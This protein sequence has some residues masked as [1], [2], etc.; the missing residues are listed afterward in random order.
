[1]VVMEW[2]GKNLKCQFKSNNFVILS[3]WLA[4]RWKDDTMNESLLFQQT[5]QTNKVFLYFFRFPKKKKTIFN[6]G[7]SNKKF[8]NGITNKQ[9]PML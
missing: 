4:E 7:V 3:T 8:I 9:A 2:I 1:M 5:G 6:G